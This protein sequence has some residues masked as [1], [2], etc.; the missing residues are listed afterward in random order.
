MFTELGPAEFRPAI[1]RFI[2]VYTAAM[3]PPE[4]MLAGREAILERHA[5][6]PGFRALAA[7]L[8]R[9]DDPPGSPREWGDSAPPIPPAP[10]MGGYPPPMPPRPAWRRACGVHLRVSRS[11]RSV[12]A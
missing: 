6:N 3:N 8:P 12:V 9:G 5:A 7:L 1:S 11:A 10:P 4:R 2:A